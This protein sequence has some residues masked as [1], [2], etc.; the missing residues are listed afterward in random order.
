LAGR[1]F[2]A[3]P[4]HAGESVADVVNRSELVCCSACHFLCRIADAGHSDAST[5]ATAG[6]GNRPKKTKRYLG[7]PRV[8]AGSRSISRQSDRST[9]PATGLGPF[10]LR[11]L[12]QERRQT[13]RP[14]PRRKQSGLEPLSRLHA[15][16]WQRTTIS[17]SLSG[18]YRIIRRAPARG[19]AYV[20]RGRTSRSHELPL[21]VLP[22]L[23]GVRASTSPFGFL[24]CC[25]RHHSAI[26]S[27]RVH[28]SEAPW[29]DTICVLI[30]L[31]MAF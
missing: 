30:G 28:P 27:H 25:G 31:T 7:G 3:P 10:G 29:W 17:A 24:R 14:L 23:C 13:L 8:R 4:P 21:L 5:R 11:S 19:L 20:G 18:R 22:R 12:R 15:A 1:E 2:G 16:L 26:V 6:V 9:E